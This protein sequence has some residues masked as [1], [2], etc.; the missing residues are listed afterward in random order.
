M[1]SPSAAVLRNGDIDVKHIPSGP[2]APGDII[3]LRVGDIVPADTRIFESYNFAVLEKMLTGES[4]PII[5]DIEP[6]TGEVGCGDRRN[7]AFLGT[8]VTAGRARGIVVTTGMGTEMGA[9]AAAL[10]GKGKKPNRSVDPKKG[11][12]NPVKGSAL[13]T[14]DVIGKFLGLTEATPLQI[15]L[16]KL[17]YV[18]FVVAIILAIVVFAVNNFNVTHEVQIYAIS[19]GLAPRFLFEVLQKLTFW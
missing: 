15:K 14:W 2:I 19:L 6:I 13:R 16:A 4:E 11:L 5:K 8:E 10:H 3:E 17:A 7:M 1:S 12:L 18:L 9:I